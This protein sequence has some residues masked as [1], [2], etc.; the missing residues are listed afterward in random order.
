MKKIVYINIPFQFSP[1]E[2]VYIAKG[3]KTIQYNNPI[4]FA[5]NAVMANKLNKGDDVQVVLLEKEHVNTP[6]YEQLFKDELGKINEKIGANIEYVSIKTKFEESYE[7][8]SELLYKSVLQL[9]K[10]SEIYADISY[11]PKTL[12]FIIFYTLKYAKKVYGANIKMVVYGK[13]DHNNGTV[14][15]PQIF[16]E[17]PFFS[18]D[19]TLELLNGMNPEEAINLFKV[20]VCI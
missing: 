17:T 2:V 6:K 5:I 3:N 18:L 9:E 20:L 12:P 13:V 14:S 8:E 10:E 15:N 19:D 4:Y 1:S 16:D 11:G 7:V